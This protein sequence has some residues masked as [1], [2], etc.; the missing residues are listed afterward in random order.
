[1]SASKSRLVLVLLLIG[2]KSGGSFFSGQ[3]QHK[4]MQKQS[5][6]NSALTLHWKQFYRWDLVQKTL[7]HI[8]SS[9]KCCC[10]RMGPWM[11]DQKEWV[12]KI[13]QK[14]GLQFPFP[15]KKVNK[16]LNHNYVFCVESHKRYSIEKL[17][18]DEITEARLIN[19][20]YWLMLTLISN[21]LK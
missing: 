20:Y 14:V 9:L 3:S 13:T 19:S 21:L 12:S 8:K 1:M 7:C 17:N 11:F 5:K 10:R 6:R 16:K 18:I 15:P 4:T 2:W